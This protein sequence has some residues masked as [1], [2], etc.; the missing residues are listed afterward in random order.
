MHFRGEAE[1]ERLIR[2][3]I[4]QFNLLSRHLEREL[5]MDARLRKGDRKT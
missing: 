1:Y 2:Q 3:N 4:Q 5:E